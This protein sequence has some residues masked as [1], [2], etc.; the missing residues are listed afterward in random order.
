[1]RFAAGFFALLMLVS[2]SSDEAPSGPLEGTVTNL[3]IED[4]DVTGFDL[5]TDSGIVPI[6]VDPQRDYGF[7]PLHLEEHQ[8]T[9]DPVVVETETQ[10][11]DEVAVSI[12]DV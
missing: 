2:C 11:G 5:V 9:G 10:D 6:V 3:N 1:M 8:S 4:G 7:D 12:E